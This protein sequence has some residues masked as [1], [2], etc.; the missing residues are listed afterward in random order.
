MFYITKYLP[1][2]DRPS[3]ILI[4]RTA[5]VGL[6]AGRSYSVDRYIVLVLVN[7]ALLAAEDDVSFL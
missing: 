3:Y 2:I 4:S 5:Q 7:D 1:A 6:L